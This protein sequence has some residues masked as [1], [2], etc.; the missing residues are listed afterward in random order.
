MEFL[1][2]ISK[3]GDTGLTTARV[4]K[5]VDIDDPKAF[6]NRGKL[7]NR[8]IRGFGFEPAEVYSNAKNAEGKREWKAGPKTAEAIAAIKKLEKE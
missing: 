8:F 5:I 3:A 4:M 7:I 2:S 6:G 1:T